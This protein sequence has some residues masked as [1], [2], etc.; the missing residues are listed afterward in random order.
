MNRVLLFV[1]LT[2]SLFELVL[3]RDRVYVAF[4]IAAL[5]LSA[6]VV[7]FIG[8]RNKRSTFGKPDETRSHVSPFAPRKVLSDL[9]KSFG[10]FL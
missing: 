6:C 7:W 4:S 10:G 8:H 5:V 2:I 9:A 1:T 3:E